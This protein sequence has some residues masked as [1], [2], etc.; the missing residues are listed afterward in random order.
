MRFPHLLAGLVATLSIAAAGNAAAHSADLSLG[1]D[2]GATDY[3]GLICSTD[4]GTE[5]DHLYVQIQSNTANGPLL[6]AQVHKGSV[7]TNITDPVSGDANPS[8]ASRTKGGNG[9]YHLLINKTGAG[10]VNYTINFHCLDATG[11]IHT[12]T[13]GVV[14][15]Y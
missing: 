9:L 10:V 11:T 5:T 12:G 1:A 3:F 15:Q 13:D 8:P 2:A 4:A 7:A 14:Y 6:S